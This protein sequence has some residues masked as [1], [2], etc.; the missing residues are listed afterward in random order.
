VSDGPKVVGPRDGEFVDLGGLGIRFMIGGE[1]TAG[2]FALVE[3]PLEPRALAAPMHRHTNEDEYSYVLEG[4]MGAKLGEDVVF[5]EPGDLIFK[6]RG[7]WHTFWNAADEGARILEL[8]SPAGF[9]RYF[10]EMIEVLR[11]GPPDP[12]VLGGIAKRHG[13]EVDLGSVQGLTEKY[14]L[15]FGPAAFE[16][17]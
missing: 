8:I 14:G 1:D 6:P 4:R 11:T 13:L 10:E 12:A 7:Q 2:Q 5:G 16:E 9:E 3:H 17:R 15:R